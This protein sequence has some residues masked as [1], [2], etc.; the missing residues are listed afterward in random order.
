MTCFLDNP[1]LEKNHNGKLT[2]LSYS[3]QNYFATGGDDNTI[4]IWD[5]SKKVVLKTLYG[6]SAAVYDLIFYENQ[7]KLISVSNDRTIRLWDVQNNDKP[8]IIKKHTGR[9]YSLSLDK[10]QRYLASGSQDRFVYIYDLKEGNKIVF[11]AKHDSDVF[12]VYFLNEK[13]LCT[14]S[15]KTI[16]IWDIFFGSE[17]PLYVLENHQAKIYN[18]VCDDVKEYAYSCSGDGKIL[19]WKLEIDSAHIKEPKYVKTF[20]GHSKEVYALVLL[21]DGKTLLSSLRDKTINV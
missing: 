11:S 18:F 6:H 15:G 13:F 7:K 16:M 10:T 8:S 4:K 2:A 14:T 5:S 20:E 17:K 19:Q 12:H 1:K 9:I 3:N 21:K